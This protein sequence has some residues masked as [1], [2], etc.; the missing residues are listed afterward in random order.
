MVLT[1][2][3]SKKTVSLMCL[4]PLRMIPRATPAA[5]THTHQTILIYFSNV[6]IPDILIR[7]Q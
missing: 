3:A 4:T 7:K 1:F 2:A 5:Y 6:C